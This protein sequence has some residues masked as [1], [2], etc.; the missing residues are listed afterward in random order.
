MT[1]DNASW[2]YDWKCDFTKWR[3]NDVTMTWSPWKCFCHVLWQWLMPVP[4]LK[5][6]DITNLTLS[7]T[8]KSEEINKNKEIII[9][10]KE[11]SDEINRWSV[12][13]RPPNNNIPLLH[14]AQYIHTT[15][16][17]SIL[18]I[19]YYPSHRFRLTRTQ[20]MHI[21]HSLG[22]IPASC[23]FTSAHL[24]IQPH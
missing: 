18:Q 12:D 10:K 17:L 2:R 3:L 20:C 8:Q 9:K 6:I 4:K 13:N 15:M 24:L 1:F 5:E 16:C 7:D 23:H 21:F 22:S 14:S 19:Y 11:N